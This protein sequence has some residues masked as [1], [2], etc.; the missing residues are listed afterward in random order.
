MSKQ[1]SGI[2]D[3]E[4]KNQG[5]KLFAARK[6]DDAISCYSKAIVS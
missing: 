5:N 1:E 2:T 6:F 4:L 3:V